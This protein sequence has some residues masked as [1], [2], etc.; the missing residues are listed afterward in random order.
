MND[1]SL[2]R[3]VLQEGNLAKGYWSAAGIGVAYVAISSFLVIVST[4]HSC[5]FVLF[6]DH[7]IHGNCG[8][9]GSSYVLYI[10]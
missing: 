6:A 1:V 10:L 5:I 9:S 7:N 8:A 3:T 2:C 4:D